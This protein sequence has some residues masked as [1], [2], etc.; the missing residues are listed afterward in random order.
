MSRLLLP[1]L[2][3]LLLTACASPP[4]PRGAPVPATQVQA[5][6]AGSPA[7]PVLAIS[8]PIVD[9]ATNQPVVA[10]VYV[11]GKRYVTVVNNSITFHLTTPQTHDIIA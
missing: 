11:D 7:G 9:A 8:G 4:G 6:G 10:G 1:L 2:L 3:S 5:A